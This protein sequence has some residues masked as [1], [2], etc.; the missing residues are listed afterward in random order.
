LGR[1]CAPVDHLTLFGLFAGDGYAP[2]GGVA[3]VKYLPETGLRPITFKMGRNLVLSG[4]AVVTI[5][6]V[7]VWRIQ[8]KQ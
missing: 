1:V 3:G 4:L 2:A 7:M 8:R 5:A 6:L